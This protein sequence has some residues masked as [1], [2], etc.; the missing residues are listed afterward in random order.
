M[1]DLELVKERLSETAI[2]DL[3]ALAE[4]TGVP[5]GTLHK[6]KYGKTKNPR[7]DTVK[8]LADYFRE[9]EAA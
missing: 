3:P 5:F 1:N 7:F 4:K 9:R 2:S 6:I 8:P